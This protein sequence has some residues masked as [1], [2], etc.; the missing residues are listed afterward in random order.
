MNKLSISDVESLKKAASFLVNM[1]EDGACMIVTDLNKIVFKQKSNQFD[2]PEYEVGV[3]NQDDGFAQQIIKTSG[4]ITFDLPGEVFNFNEVGF[5]VCFAG[6]PIFDEEDNIV[7]T[8]SMAYPIRHDLVKAF[9][10]F[11]EIID[12]IL[13]GRMSFY[14]TDKKRITDATKYIKL[15]Y[16]EVAAIQPGAEL[17]SEGAA[18]VAIAKKQLTDVRIPRGVFA[19]GTACEIAAYPL[20]VNDDAIGSLCAIIDRELNEEIKEQINMLRD[21]I[22]Q[23]ASAVEEVAISVTDV[24][25]QQSQ[26]SL[27]V[28]KIA[29]A[30]EKIENVSGFIT[31]VADETKML[32][33]NAAIEA[34]R[35]GEAGRGFS[36]VAEEIRKLSEQSKQT[37]AEIISSIG[38]IKEQ[39]EL[40]SEVAVK[41]ESAAEQQ[42]AA[43]QEINASVEEI[44]ALAE[45][46]ANQA[47]DL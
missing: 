45:H 1:F 46:L 19:G 33:L 9:S 17:T 37:V 44:G 28:E 5:K 3:A 47:Q 34:A 41:T 20:I 38:E 32:G 29:E 4:F 27:Q 35:A 6:T 13:K 2:L 43:T 24:T 42:A 25:T 23:I 30:S 15:N 36:V 26:L 39:I 16:S 8:W 10:T 14:L 11:G 31:A 40:T 22:Q 7:G 12:I 18:G 21:S